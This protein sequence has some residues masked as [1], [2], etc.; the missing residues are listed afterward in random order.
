MFPT[1]YFPT[2]LH[3]VEIWSGEPAAVYLNMT[4]PLRLDWVVDH[5]PY[6][7]FPPFDIFLYNR[8]ESTVPELAEFEDLAESKVDSV[9]WTEF[10]YWK[11]EILEACE[12]HRDFLGYEPRI[13]FVA[14]LE[15]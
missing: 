14:M 8:A 3:A 9:M 2:D 10:T 1:E 12:N 11:Q 15:K 7:R 5:L 6:H 13:H 4:I